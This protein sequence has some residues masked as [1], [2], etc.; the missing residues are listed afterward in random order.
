MQYFIV[1]K[2]NKYF[3][4][5]TL[6]IE[7]G[8]SEYGQN[9]SIKITGDSKLYLIHEYEVVDDW[10]ADIGAISHYEKHKQYVGKIVYA[11]DDIEQVSL[12]YANYIYSQRIAV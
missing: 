12:E 4:I 11:S 1:K 3:L 2:K 5:D 6:P 9:T 8:I 10:Y 7:L